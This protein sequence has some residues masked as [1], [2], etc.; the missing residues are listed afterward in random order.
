MDALTRELWW[1]TAMLVVRMRGRA[2]EG[3]IACSPGRNLPP[4]TEVLCGMTT[5]H[6]SELAN[7]WETTYPIGIVD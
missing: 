5:I 6:L 3:G 2:R 4:N 1:R 7:I